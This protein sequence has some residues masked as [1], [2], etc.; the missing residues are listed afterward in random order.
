MTDLTDLHFLMLQV[1]LGNHQWLFNVQSGESPC[2]CVR[3]D[4]DGI[5]WQPDADLPDP[6]HSPWSHLATFD[7]FG[8]VHASKQQR[9]F[10]ACAPDFSYALVCDSV[11]HMYVYR[12]PT[13]TET[14]L[15][16]RKTGRQVNSVA[17]QQ[18]ISLESVDTITGLFAANNCIFAV[19]G[20]TVHVLR[21]A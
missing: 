6:S 5:V 16:N 18:L 2:L 4:V 3:H 14:A 7:A 17:K 21:L 8:Y 20:D 15:R 12:Q 1:N 13:P 11:R 10:T 19:A 9:K